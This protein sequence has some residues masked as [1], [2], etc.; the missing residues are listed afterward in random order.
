M[1][2]QIQEMTAADAAQ[3]ASKSGEN[4]FMFINTANGRLSYIDPHGVLSH[5]TAGGDPIILTAGA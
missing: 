2:T 1:N 3:T 5:F 4:G